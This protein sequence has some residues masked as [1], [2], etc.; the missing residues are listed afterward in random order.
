MAWRQGR[1]RLA[2]APDDP[3]PAPGTAQNS[4]VAEVVDRMVALR[5]W[6]ERSAEAAIRI[7]R[8]SAGCPSNSAGDGLPAPAAPPASGVLAAAQEDSSIIRSYALR[9]G[10]YFFTPV[11]GANLLSVRAATKIWASPRF[12]KQA[13][14]SIDD[15]QPLREAVHGA[16]SLGPRTREEI[17]TQVLAEPT[18]S[19]LQLGLSGAGAD[20]LYKPLHWWGDI[21]FGPTRDGQATFRWLADD[22]AW[23]GLPPAHEAG[24]QAMGDYMHS[25]GPVT[26]A[27]L[28]YWFTEGLG[29]RR[30]QLEEW[31]TA[32]G[33]EL[34]PVT[35][36]GSEAFVLAADL[37]DIRSTQ[38][39]ETLLFLPSFDPWLLGPGTADTRI[40]AAS[41]RAVA[42]RGANTIVHNGFV[43]GT[44]K[45]VAHEVR[46]SWFAEAGALPQSLLDEQV[47]VLGR[48][49][50]RE[51]TAVL[52]TG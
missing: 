34:V 16:C 37:D 35:V 18:L 28:H 24:V 8:A 25:Y 26:R 48:T 29:V 6:P 36:A 20:S 23:P 5:A 22:P 11:R 15:W 49:L 19:H 32:L 40:I 50:N 9:G 4:A 13:S 42:S 27:N 38:Q 33:D 47:Q 46:I 1:H 30:A 21:C 14:F 7:R 39:V 41:R 44:W 12:Q 3:S 43:V 45:T 17:S 10:S 51:L 31:M 2:T 52:T